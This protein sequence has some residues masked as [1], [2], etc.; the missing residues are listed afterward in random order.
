MTL[1]QA[2]LQWP[3]Q[4]AQ[5]VHAA[6]FL[7]AA[8]LHP[9]R[10]R[11]LVPKALWNLSA[12]RLSPALAA[13]QAWQEF[14][15]RRLPHRLALLPREVVDRVAWNLGL[16][17]SAP[18]LRQV[19]LRSELQQLADQGLDEDAWQ[20][21]LLVKGAPAA[22]D[23]GPIE[24][25]GQAIKQRGESALLGLAEEIGGGLGQRLTFK[26]APALPVAAPA[27]T[28]LLDQAYTPVVQAWSAQWDRCLAQA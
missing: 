22:Q 12:A 2:L 15:G 11:E 26:L 24:Q 14:D 17:I 8:D 23:L 1:A 20:L 3:Q 21:V 5:Q 27:A 28:D 25:W 6:L 4:V 16:L 18:R 10:A 9:Q 7:P 19:V 13:P